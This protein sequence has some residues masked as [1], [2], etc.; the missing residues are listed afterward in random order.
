MASGVRMKQTNEQTWWAQ[1]MS[2]QQHRAREEFQSF[3]G[4]VRRLPPPHPTPIPPPAE[5]LNRTRVLLPLH[6]FVTSF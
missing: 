1:E 3:R 6:G 5:R 4:S 2:R